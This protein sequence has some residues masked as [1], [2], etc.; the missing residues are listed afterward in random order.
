MS[1]LT[2]INS[3]GLLDVTSLPTATE[4]ILFSVKTMFVVAG[5]V[6]L[7]FALL[8]SRQIN[9][10]SKTLETTA[11]VHIKLLGMLHFVASV[12]ALIYFFIVL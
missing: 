1:M 4:A 10:M 3:S 8:V 9:I 6:Y 5:I 11:S 2:L 12:V 7:L